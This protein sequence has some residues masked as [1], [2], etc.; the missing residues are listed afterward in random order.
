VTPE[1]SSLT[2]REAPPDS[3][4]RLAIE[5][6]QRDPSRFADLYEG[7]FERVYAFVLRRVSNRAEAED[8]TSDVFH[9]ALANI[10]RFEWRRA[11]FA[12]WL[13]RIAS[14]AIASHFE[15]NE[16]VAPAAQEDVPEPVVMR[17][18]EHRAGLYRM[19][20]Q[21]PPLQQRVLRMRFG[22]EKSIREIALTLKKTEGAVKQ[23]QLRALRKL[24]S[25]M[26][27]KHG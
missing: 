4:E 14:N 8:L 27:E 2:G 15:K 7:H 21:L 23:L 13:F 22:G 16:R 5:A 9:K 6:A 10:G 17:E 18:V 20:A 3:E 19:V 11:P 26:D 1:K 12:A 25:R 24:R